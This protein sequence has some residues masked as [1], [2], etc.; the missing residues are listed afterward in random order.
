VSAPP[1]DLSVILPAYNEAECLPGVLRELAGV[2]T[3]RLSGRTW[4]ILAVDDGST[5]ATAER[6]RELQRE[7]PGLRVLTL[8]RNQGQSAAFWAGFRAAR[9]PVLVTLDADGQNDPAGIPDLIAALDRADAACGVRLNRRDTWSKRLGSRL[10]NA[11]RNRALGERVSDTGCALKA[12]RRELVDDLP[13]WNGF[14]RFL[15]TWFRLHGARVLEVPVRHR[16]RQSGRSKYTNW[17]RLWRTLR[18]LRGMAWL[19]S[20]YVRVEARET[21]SPSG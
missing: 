11:V 18:D 15:P 14:H 1:P 21:P 5:D 4:E 7:I 19:G 6:L 2:L 20:R 9:A 12:F 8:A 10:A 16:P 13:P 3:G 17:G